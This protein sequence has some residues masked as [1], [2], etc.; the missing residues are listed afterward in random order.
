[1]KT[2]AYLSR[3][4]GNAGSGQS[5]DQGHILVGRCEDIPHRNGCVQSETVVTLVR[6]FTRG[7]LT[8]LMVGPL[9]AALIAV[10]GF[11]PVTGMVSEVN[12]CG[13]A[14]WTRV[15]LPLNTAIP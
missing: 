1:M 12:G 9:V 13:S 10:S 14:A 5:P 2:Y 7:L 6:T 3:D 11:W 8:R 4:Q 15:D